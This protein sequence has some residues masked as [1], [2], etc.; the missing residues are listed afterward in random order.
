MSSLPWNETTPSSSHLLS[1]SSGLSLGLSAKSPVWLMCGWKSRLP[2]PSTSCVILQIAI[3]TV[4]Y[5]FRNQWIEPQFCNIEF[6][7]YKLWNWKL[8]QV[9]QFYCICTLCWLIT[10]ITVKQFITSKSKS[11]SNKTIKSILIQTKTLH[12]LNN[13]PYQNFTQQPILSQNKI[14]LK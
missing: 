1:L 12:M 3:L 11:I 6:S 9:M 8:N 2:F 7:K 4:Y 10:C 14:V 5:T 13:L